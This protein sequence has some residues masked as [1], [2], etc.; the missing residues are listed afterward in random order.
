M[1]PTPESKLLHEFI[2]WLGKQDPPMCIAGPV[3][4]PLLGSDVLCGLDP[5]DR[6]DVILDFLKRDAQ[7]QP[8]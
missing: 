5:D 4:D 3:R 8:S 1:N 6:S 7:G 2:Q